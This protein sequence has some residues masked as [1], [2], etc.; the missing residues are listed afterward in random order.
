M[1]IILG[2]VV[3][4]LPPFQLP[5]QSRDPPMISVNG[6]VVH[7]PTADTVYDPMQLMEDLGMGLL[8]LPIVSILPQAATAKFYARE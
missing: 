3:A 1:K 6:S 8:L 5:W 4:G 2:N 7:N